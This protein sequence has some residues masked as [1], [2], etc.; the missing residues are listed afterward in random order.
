MSFGR[1]SWVAFASVTIACGGSVATS[2]AGTDG[3]V[4]QDGSVE[5]CPSNPP[6]PG[7]SCSTNTLTCEYGTNPDPSCN[8]MFQC[9]S[10]AWV[11]QSTGTY[12]PPQQTCPGSYA[13]VPVNQDCTPQ[14]LTCA[15]PEG[16]CIC[17][18]SFGGLQKQTPA[19]NCFPK[20]D[21]CP[22]PRP[23]IGSSCTTPGQNCDYG[24]CSGGVALG[25]VNGV[26]QRA[27][28]LCPG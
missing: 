17:T 16:E 19:W 10:G 5:A 28:V 7:G 3:N 18:T 6:T 23:D 11:D 14:T 12:C 27:E 20:I 4:G 22:S 26:W 1:L 9:T 8:Q 24:A 21:G 25:C 15:Y 2:D 13:Q